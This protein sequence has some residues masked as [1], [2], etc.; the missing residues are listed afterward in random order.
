MRLSI[1]LVKDLQNLANTFDRRP[2]KE[3][4]ILVSPDD[5]AE[6]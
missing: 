3:G 4:I 2:K 6:F 5:P 1:E